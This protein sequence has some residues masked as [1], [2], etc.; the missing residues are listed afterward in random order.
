VLT[1]VLK[2]AVATAPLGIIKP[3]FTAL[4]ALIC[5]RLFVNGRELDGLPP[6]KLSLSW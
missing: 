4:F 2:F 3:I 6:D 1:A 5:N